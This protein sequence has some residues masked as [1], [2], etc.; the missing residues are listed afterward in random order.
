FCYALTEDLWVIGGAV[1]SGG[2]VLQWLREQ[3]GARLGQGNGED[4]YTALSELAASVPPGADGLLFLPFLMGERAPYWNEDA[5]AVLFGLAMHHSPRHWVRAA[6]EGVM[7]QLYNVALVLEQLA[8]PFEEVRANGGF[9]RSLLWRQIMADVFGKTVT[10]PDNYESSCWGAA[11]L[12]L[13]SLGAVDSLAA[14]KSA[15]TCVDRHVPNPANYHLY[16]ERMALFQ[17]LYRK[18]TE[19]F[20]VV[21]AWQKQQQ[22]AGDCE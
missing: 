3:L 7:L 17:R 12:G 2:I 16:Q 13:W 8:G 22:K 9:T 4:A 6:L 21:A 10:V 18:L 19:E 5:R 1:N 14:A 15:V 20:R 11:V